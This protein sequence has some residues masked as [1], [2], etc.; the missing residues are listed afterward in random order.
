MYHTIAQYIYIY[1]Y[2]YIEEINQELKH[3]T[4]KIEVCDRVENMAHRQAFISLITSQS[5]PEVKKSGECGCYGMTSESCKRAIVI[6]DLI[7]FAVSLQERVEINFIG[8]C[9]N[10]RGGSLFLLWVGFAF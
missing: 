4:T 7:R 8:L 1:T 2:I 5:Q 3:I 9:T 6:V 10:S